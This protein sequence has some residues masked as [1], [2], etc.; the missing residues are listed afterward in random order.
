MAGLFVFEISQTRVAGRSKIRI[1]HLKLN[2]IMIFFITIILAYFRL[3]VWIF[4]ALLSE[5]SVLPFGFRLGISTLFW[6]MSVGF[7]GMMFLRDKSIPLCLGH[8]LYWGTTG[9]QIGRAHV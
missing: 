4:R 6:L 8:A 9:W 5:I 2:C 7:F 3:H 1:Y